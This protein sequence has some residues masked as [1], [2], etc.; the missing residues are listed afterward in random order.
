M[1]NSHNSRF[2]VAC[3]CALNVLFVMVLFF[4]CGKKVTKVEPQLPAPIKPV[5]T[6]KVAPIERESFDTVAMAEELRS[7]LQPIY[8]DFDKADL[9]L[10]AIDRLQIIGKLLKERQSVSILVEGNCDE[11][12][13]A[14][15]NMALGERRAR[16]AKSWL[17]NYGIQDHRVE[18]TSYG[19]ERLAVANCVDEPCHA[20]NRR[21]EF[22]VLS[23]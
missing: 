4:G 8:F 12:G 17:S 3:S 1:N 6:A 16:A 7:A 9:R 14:E 22:K 23:K 15:Y 5:D 19:K 21:N 13:S 2:F 20:K 11:R 18:I 10:D